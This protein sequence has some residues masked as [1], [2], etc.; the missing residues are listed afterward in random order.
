MAQSLISLVAH[1]LPLW[2]SWTHWSYN[3]VLHAPSAGHPTCKI[4]TPTRNCS[5][6]PTTTPLPY[7]CLKCPTIIHP[8]PCNCSSCPTITPLLPPPLPCLGTE[9]NTRDYE[10]SPPTS[11]AVVGNGTESEGGRE[12]E[13]KIG[14]GTSMELGGGLGALVIILILILVG[15]ILV[16]VWSCHRRWKPSQERWETTSYMKN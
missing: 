4:L 11:M 2:I 7:D 6:C 3:Q 14:T 12:K 13:Q 8:L 15:L 10:Q 1:H 16:W 9:T 5:T